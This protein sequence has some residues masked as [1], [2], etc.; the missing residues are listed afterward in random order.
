MC[1]RGPTRLGSLVVVCFW[2]S[3]PLLLFI[4]LYL[5]P[6]TFLS[7]ILATERWYAESYRKFWQK[8]SS[9]CI[10]R[11][12]YLHSEINLL[13]HVNHLCL[14]WHW[15]MN[16]KVVFHPRMDYDASPEFE[17][18]C[19]KTSAQYRYAH[20]NVNTTRAKNAEVSEEEEEEEEV[21]GERHGPGWCWNCVC[22]VG[23]AR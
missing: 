17:N 23:G 21:V 3:F 19:I 5:S 9:F 20:W 7:L 15:R 2:A 22:E 10:L 8:K 4:S 16:Y 12:S 6:V 11:H 1:G 18:L 13:I 14:W